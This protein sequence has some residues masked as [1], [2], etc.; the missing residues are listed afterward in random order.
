MLRNVLLALAAAL[1]L[2]MPMLAQAAEK[3]PAPK[4]D[5]ISHHGVLVKPWADPN[6]IYVCIDG[7]T[8]VVM[9]GADSSNGL[10]Q[11]ID[12]DKDGLP[13]PVPC[14]NSTAKE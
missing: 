11:L 10:A 12:R 2:A 7:R 4:G 1:V 14:G 5:A 3:L 8:F 6:I 13:G 9:Y